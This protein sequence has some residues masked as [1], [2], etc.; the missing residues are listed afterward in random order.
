MAEVHKIETELAA[1]FCSKLLGG[2]K[3][4]CAIRLQ[5][6]DNNKTRC[7]VLVMPKDPYAISH[8]AGHCLGVDHG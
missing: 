8:E 2:V 1:E 3:R 4:A 6:M 7:V 5:N